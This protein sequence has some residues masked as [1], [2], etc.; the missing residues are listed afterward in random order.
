MLTVKEFS[1]ITGLKV[2]TVRSWIYKKKIDFKKEKNGKV[3]IFDSELDRIGGDVMAVRN[4]YVNVDVDG[5]KTKMKGGP[6]NKEG[7]MEITLLQRD[8]G[9]KVVAFIINSY[10][11]DGIL[12]SNVMDK[13]RN[14]LTTFQTER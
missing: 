6:R 5:Y 13:D 7:G 14:V 1:N 11:K 3:F 8:K 12:Y 4:F 2:R 9:S 10:E